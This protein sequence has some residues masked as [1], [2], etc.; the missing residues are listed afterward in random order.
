[1]TLQFPTKY[2]LAFDF[3]DASVF[4]GETVNPKGYIKALMREWRSKELPV[5]RVIWKWTDLDH[6]RGSDL[7][8]KYVARYRAMIAGKRLRARGLGQDGFPVSYASSSLYYRPDVIE[9]AGA[10]QWGYGDLLLI[11]GVTAKPDNPPAPSP[12]R[13]LEWVFVGGGLALMASVT[14][15]IFRGFSPIYDGQGAHDD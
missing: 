14:L 3:A 5:V 6:G 2:M 8:A 1:M 10:T 11:E 15:C 12:R 9:K 13:G 7:H 4:V